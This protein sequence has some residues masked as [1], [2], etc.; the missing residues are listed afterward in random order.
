MLELDPATIDSLDSQGADDRAV[1]S[2]AHTI[3]FLLVALSLAI[4]GAIQ[5]PISAWPHSLVSQQARLLLYGQIV[6]LQL[7]WVGYVWWGIRHSATSVR[8]LIDA[9]RWT[10]RRWL[11][12]VAVGIAGFILYMAIGAGL[13]KILQPSGEALRGLQAMLPHTTVERWFWTAFA[14]SVGVGEEV[15]YRGYLMTQFRSLTHSTIA[16]VTLQA[17]C[18]ALI[19]LALPVEI[20]AGVAILGLLLGA[21]ALW[22]KSLVPGMVLHVAVGL[23]AMV[24]PT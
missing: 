15:V 18:Y 23:M 12:Y 6:V 3:G 5:S 8:A 13:S 14:L 17:L 16:A 11:R 21:I 2:W 1:A 7:I 22:Q 4:G 20:L 19:H 9:S 24:R 10:L